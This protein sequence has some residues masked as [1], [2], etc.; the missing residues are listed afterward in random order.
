VPGAF[1]VVKSVT[2]A[3]ACPDYLNEPS[4]TYESGGK[5][6]VLCLEQTK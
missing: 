4:L 1:K 3:S 6:T 2:T 5:T